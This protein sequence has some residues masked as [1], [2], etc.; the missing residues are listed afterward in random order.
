MRSILL[1][2]LLEV[3]LDK[4][5]KSE[6]REE[7]VGP[8]L[9]LLHR[10]AKEMDPIDILRI[11]PDQW[12]LAALLPALNS[13]VRAK[14]HERRMTSVKRHLAEAENLNMQFEG[15]QLVENPIFVLEN[16][17]C[18]MCK[19][20][21]RCPNVSR[22]PNGVVLHPECVKDVSICPI[23]GQIFKMDKATSS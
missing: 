15:L 14:I 11:L 3:Y 16:S 8:A 10:R 22:Y 7:L 12:S 9:D 4:N 17:Y 21:F 23:T 19:K 20:T 1:N 5:L 13:M 18:M 6:K 2:K